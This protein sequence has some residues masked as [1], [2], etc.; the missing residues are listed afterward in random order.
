MKIDSA[1]HD[2]NTGLPKDETHFEK[3]LPDYLQSSVK[4]MCDSKITNISKNKN[5]EDCCK[6]NFLRG[7]SEEAAT[8]FEANAAPKRPLK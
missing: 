7:D 3:G 1:K 5:P 4:R 6:I 8:R 2:R